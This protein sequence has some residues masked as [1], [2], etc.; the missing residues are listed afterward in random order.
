MAGRRTQPGGITGHR[1]PIRNGL[2]EHGC[3]G[4]VRDLHGL[5]G[6]RNGDRPGAENYF[7]ES[8]PYLDDSMAVV[9]NALA[10]TCGQS[11]RAPSGQT[12]VI[13]IPRCCATATTS[14][15]PPYPRAG[16]PSHTANSSSALSS[17]RSLAAW[18]ASDVD[19]R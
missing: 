16:F 19:S 8:V 15:V 10:K 13:G 1:E 17:M 12:T 6:V 18:C 5:V 9:L 4:P 14:A 11:R 7:R 2:L 3:A